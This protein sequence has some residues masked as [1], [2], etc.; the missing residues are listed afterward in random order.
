MF[1]VSLLQTQQAQPTGLNLMSLAPILIVF[2]I[3]YFFIIRPQNK[4]QKETEKMINAL[5][6]GDKV[7]TIGGIHGVVTSTKEKT[8]V[9]KVDSSTSIEFNRTAISTV[10]VD[11]PAEKKS[12]SKKDDRDEVKAE[13][14]VK[15]EK[16]QA[17][18][19]EEASSENK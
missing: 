5:K 7:V 4:R 12:K 19:A 6:K 10:I 8:V 2:V 18:A 15:A 11:K 17:E 14:A 9:V 1:F 16:S 3:F 13:E